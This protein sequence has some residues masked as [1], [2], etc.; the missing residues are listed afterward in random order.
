MTPEVQDELKKPRVLDT[1]LFQLPVW[2]YTKVFVGK[3][4][5]GKTGKTAD[6]KMVDAMIAEAKKD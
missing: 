2:I 3:K 6:A 4:V 1:V 5:D